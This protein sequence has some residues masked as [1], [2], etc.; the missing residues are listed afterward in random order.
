MMSPVLLAGPSGTP[1]PRPRGMGRVVR[2][3]VALAYLTVLSGCGGAPTVSVGGTSS[4]TS[5]TTTLGSLP[6][7]ST[8][9]AT[10]ADTAAQTSAV[11]TRS[12]ATTAA[13]T[14]SA[15]SSSSVTGHATTAQQ[16]SPAGAV[17]EHLKAAGLPID[18]IVVYTAETDPNHLLGR[19]GQYVSKAAF[20][21]T[22][23]QQGPDVANGGSIES[24]AT[25]T[26]LENRKA[27]VEKIAK[28]SPLFAEY[29]YSAGL[30]LLRL[31]STLTP[32]Q[33]A[34]YQKAL[35]AASK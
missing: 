11:A 34:V 8:I 25:S 29:D 1:A 23:L 24:F 12:S 9:A 20:H 26:D 4:T 30:V 15:A 13:T 5:A 19:P 3:L 22:R 7:P 10:S 35:P 17:A 28:S 6:A 14:A 2:G 31:S 18:N 32:D 27:Y 33:A 16:E 21:D